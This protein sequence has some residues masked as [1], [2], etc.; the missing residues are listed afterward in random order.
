[1]EKNKMVIDSDEDYA[2]RKLN[3]SLGKIKGWM[4]TREGIGEFHKDPTQFVAGYVPIP[5][6]NLRDEVQFYNVV[7]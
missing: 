2:D 4:G 6:L 5:P 1:M 7:F 3:P